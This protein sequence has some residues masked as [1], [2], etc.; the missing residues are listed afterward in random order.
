MVSPSSGIGCRFHCLE[1]AVL[2]A[3]MEILNRR[4]T[5]KAGVVALLCASTVTYWGFVTKQV[6]AN[7]RIKPQPS[8]LFLLHANELV[9]S[10]QQHGLSLLMLIAVLTSINQHEQDY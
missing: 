3:G 8:C 10:N 4:R 6:A 5:R 1:C 2:S 9:V 7:G